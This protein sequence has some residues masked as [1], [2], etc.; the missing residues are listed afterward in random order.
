[1][2]LGLLTVH[3]VMVVTA[4]VFSA[5][6]AA[7]ELVLAIRGGS[8]LAAVFAAFSALAALLLAL[9]LRWLLR[10]KGRKLCAA[11]APAP[12]PPRTDS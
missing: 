1:M 10:T 8:A 6:F 2:S 3:K 4:I 5:G 12:R 9:Y 11:S 7:R